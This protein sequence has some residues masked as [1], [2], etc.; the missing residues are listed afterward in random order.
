[1]FEREIRLYR[2]MLGYLQT[3][4][5]DLDD[6]HWMLPISEGVN[7]PA[8]ILGHLATTN[9]SALKIFGCATLCPKEWYAA[10]GRGKKPADMTI[11][12][13]SK[14]ELIEKIEQGHALI[15]EAARS[16][17]PTAMEKPHTIP[18]FAGSPIETVGDI[19]AHLLTTHFATHIGQLSL[20]RRQLGFAPV[21]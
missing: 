1:M 17:N 13:P 4:A 10:F 8:W 14:S 5:K 19:V 3:I 2:L 18:M 20:I 7:P 15:C 11:S 12:Y 9:D 16:A 6:S 21:F